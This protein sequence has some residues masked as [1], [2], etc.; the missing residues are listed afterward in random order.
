M[1]GWW[2]VRNLKLLYNLLMSEALPEKELT[3]DDY[4]AL[5]SDQ[6]WEL[7]G[8]RLYLMASP[9]VRHQ[10]VCGELFANLRSHFRGSPCQVFIAPLDLKLSHRDALQPDVM[11]VCD[12]SKIT[13]THIE[14]VPDLVIEVLSPSSM[15]KD[16]M[17]KLQLYARA[18]VKEYWIVEP[19]PPLAELLLLDGQSYR[20]HGTYTERDTL[21]SPS[22]P[23]LVINLSEIFP[24]FDPSQVQEESS[25]YFV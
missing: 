15:R 10:R 14:G 3:W 19:H 11:V 21:K 5:P 25:P 13:E 17:Q 4:R 8:G 6:R 18:G 7:M 22:F 12:A 20:I 16:R 23:D 9:T 1:K 24:D 2:C